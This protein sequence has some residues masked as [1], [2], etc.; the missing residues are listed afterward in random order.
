MDSSSAVR[1]EYHCKWRAHITSH[2][3][4]SRAMDG[5][6]RVVILLRPPLYRN[7][8]MSAAAPALPLLQGRTGSRQAEGLI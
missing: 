5:V 3:E 8:M 7:R 2:H 1:Q 4:G 6:D